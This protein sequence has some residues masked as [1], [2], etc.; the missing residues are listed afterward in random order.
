MSCVQHPRLQDPD[1][2]DSSTGSTVPVIQIRLDRVRSLH[3]EL[4]GQEYAH[5]SD[6]PQGSNDGSD[7]RH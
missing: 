7:R 6:L 1:A 5:D 4:P 2:V 3:R